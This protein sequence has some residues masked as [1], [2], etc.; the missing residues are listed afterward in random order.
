MYK[1]I[2]HFSYGF[3]LI[4]III[5][6]FV[7]IFSFII[8]IMVISRRYSSISRASKRTRRLFCFYRDIGYKSQPLLIENGVLRH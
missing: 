1:G 3:S 8:I 4:I 6:Y 7:M 2:F 5:I